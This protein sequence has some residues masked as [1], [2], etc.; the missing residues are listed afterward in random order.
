L[1]LIWKRLLGL[2]KNDMF[3]VIVIICA[4]GI[5]NKCITLEDLFGPYKTEIECNQ[6]AFEISLQIHTDLPMWE[7][8][9]WKCE[10]TIIGKLIARN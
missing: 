10:K 7:P 3:K 4:I 2:I 5:P 6:R 9:K 1:E 8:I